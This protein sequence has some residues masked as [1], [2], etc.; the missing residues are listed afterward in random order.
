MKSDG[1][2][3]SRISSSSLANRLLLLPSVSFTITFFPGLIALLFQGVTSLDMRLSRF[4]SL[5]SLNETNTNGHKPRLAA[6][7]SPQKFRAILRLR[8]AIV[9][10]KV[11]VPG[12]TDQLDHERGEDHG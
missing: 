11:A 10:A 1:A 4:F 12:I 9:P 6:I 8:R 3:Q 2:G 5:P 7:P